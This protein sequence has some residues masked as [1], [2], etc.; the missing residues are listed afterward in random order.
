MAIQTL[1]T[2]KNWFK[3]G[4]K[5]TQAQF[6]DTWD[7]FRHKSEKVPAA[8]IEGMDALLLLKA[9]K[10]V[11]DDHLSNNT[12]HSSLFGAKEDKNKKGVANGYAPL[13]YLTKLASQYLN[14]VND[15]VTGGSD[16]LLSAEQGKLLQS[17]INNINVLLASDNVNLDNV[18]EIVDAI[19][20]VQTSLST[21]L[22]NDLTTGGT[23][24]AL[25]AE[26]G[27]SLK[28][29]H[30]ALVTTV[31]G[32][33]DSSNKVQDIETNKTSTSFYASVK[34]TYDW[35]MSKFRTWVY[36]IN[37]QAGITYTFALGDYKNIT[38]FLNANPVALTIP[39]NASVAIP[40]G[41]TFAYTQQG[42]GV[43]TVGGA[44]ITFVT[45]FP[46]AS[47]QGETRYVT[48]I[49][50]DTWVLEG[51]GIDAT[52]IHKTGDE[53]K[54]GVLNFVNTLSS[55]VNGISMSNS[56]GIGS[57]SLYVVNSASGNG[58]SYENSGSGKGASF[59]NSSSGS[60]VYIDNQSTGKGFYLN[61]NGTGNGI[62]LVNPNN[63]YGFYMSNPGVGTGQFI[64]NPSTGTGFQVNNEANGRGIRVNNLGVG[65]GVFIQNSTTGRAIVLNNVTAASGIL[66]SIQKNGLD[67]FLI[68][69]AGEPTATKYRLSALNTAPS[70]ATDTGTLGEIRFTATYIYVCTA[71]N[72][73]VRTA[74]TTW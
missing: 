69:D 32:K 25:T 61:N 55:L 2:I 48:K 70:S 10:V 47:V 8:D 18:Q 30:D 21:I 57:K 65:Y 36:G 19:E 39:T 37:A 15:L 26:M 46:L 62:E 72:T 71:T 56:G 1:N 66:F 16:S 33:E 27:K 60:G 7:S 59:V 43:V 14:I 34:Q 38:V 52:A 35:C 74:L 24:K 13:D 44:G 40:V 9:D 28:S 58:A 42:T 3:T 63:T 20:T 29:L 5:P 45:N 12:A 49:G 17:Q 11:L 6:W 54:T 53:T 68:N 31:S 4:L 23:T 51:S 22:V 67:T 50:T 64:N 41:T 73:W